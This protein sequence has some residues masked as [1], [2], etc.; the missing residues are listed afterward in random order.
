MGA[1]VACARTLVAEVVKTISGTISRQPKWIQHQSYECMYAHYQLWA[2][3]SDEK[4]AS[5]RTFCRVVSSKLSTTWSK[6]IRIRKQSQ[7]ARLASQNQCLV[8]EAPLRCFRL[9]PDVTSGAQHAR[10]SQPGS[11]MHCRRLTGSLCKRRRSST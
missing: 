1:C 2:G 5:Y 6:L 10:G 9:I 3:K 4:P 11:G 7:H 8:K